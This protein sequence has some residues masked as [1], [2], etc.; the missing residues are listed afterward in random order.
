MKNESPCVSSPMVLVKFVARTL[1]E[2]ESQ[3]GSRDKMETGMVYK[4]TLGPGITLDD[5]WV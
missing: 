5:G 1:D 4:Y 2:K 3:P